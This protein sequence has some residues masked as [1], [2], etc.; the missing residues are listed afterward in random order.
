MFAATVPPT[1]KTPVAAL[2]GI[3]RPGACRRASARCGDLVLRL[4]HKGDCRL[5]KAAGAAHLDVE[6][7]ADQADVLLEQRA[8]ELPLVRP[9][10]Q[11]LQ[12]RTKDMGVWVRISR[13]LGVAEQ[14][15]EPNPD[16][17]EINRNND[18]VVE[19]DQARCGLGG[20]TVVMTL[21]PEQRIVLEWLLEVARVGIGERLRP[22]AARRRS[23]DRLTLEQQGRRFSPRQRRGSHRPFSLIDEARNVPF[24]A[25]SLAI[26]H[27]F[28]V[29]L[30]D[31][32]VVGREHAAGGMA[33]PL[34]QQ[35]DM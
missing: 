5:L 4:T 7:A 27:T 20:V 25:G 1:L 3:P 34:L 26:L 15:V 6:L 29:E 2:H 9:P 32:V 24:E 22:V 11:H 17:I 8:R 30:A 21:E 33:R 19:R 31:E 35:E 13:H 12:P 18:A 23:I 28:D 16:V 14:R 10:G